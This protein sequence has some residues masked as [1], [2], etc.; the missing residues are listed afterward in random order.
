MIII[1]IHLL[2]LIALIKSSFSR[3]VSF[4]NLFKNNKIITSFNLT[5]SNSQTLIKDSSSSFVIM[6]KVCMTTSFD[7]FYSGCFKQ[8]QGYNNK[9]VII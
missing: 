4:L 9:W 5:L 8:Y 1:K 6:G 7:S 3:E 2:L